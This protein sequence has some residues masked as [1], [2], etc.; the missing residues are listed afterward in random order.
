MRVS[1]H[2]VYNLVGRRRDAGGEGPYLACA[3]VG[4]ARRQHI[5]HPQRR[6]RR[7]VELL[8]ALVAAR[9]AAYPRAWA[10][11]IEPIFQGGR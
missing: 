2:S 6:C 5:P 4:Q 9:E 3:A 10:D 8:D 1:P 7:L 11:A